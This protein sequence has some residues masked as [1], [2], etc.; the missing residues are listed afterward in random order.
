MIRA[1]RFSAGGAASLSASARAFLTTILPNAEIAKLSKPFGPGTVFS[2]VGG[3][4]GQLALSAG[5]IVA[6]AGAAVGGQIYTITIRAANLSGTQ[7]VEIALGFQ[8]IA[9]VIIS[10]AAPDATVGAPYDFVLT[11]GAP[12]TITADNPAVAAAHGFQIDSAA[13]R[14]FSTGVIA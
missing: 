10:G 3:V 1:P 7:A 9:P 2:T 8:A 4:P 6:G 5:T 13:K 14:I 12:I 11:S